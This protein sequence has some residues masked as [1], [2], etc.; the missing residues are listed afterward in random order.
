MNVIINVPCQ[1]NILS[2]HDEIIVDITLKILCVVIFRFSLGEKKTV[3]CFL[4][5]L[6]KGKT[7]SMHPL[8]KTLHVIIIHFTSFF[9][10]FI[11]CNVL[12]ESVG[13]AM[14]ADPGGY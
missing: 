1:L 2:T 12:V 10:L 4:L 5:T 9:F 6:H 7:K 14:K 11:L 3:N 13:T 8:N